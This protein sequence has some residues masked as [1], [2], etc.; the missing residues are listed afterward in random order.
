[1]RPA[2]LAE[3]LVETG[4]D[5]LLAA[6]LRD[7]TGE[8]QPAQQL[9]TSVPGGGCPTWPGG[10]AGRVSAPA[11]PAGCAAARYRRWSGSTLPPK[12]KTSK[13]SSFLLF[14]SIKSN[15][16]HPLINLPCHPFKLPADRWRQTVRQIS[17]ANR[18]NLKPPTDRPLTSW[19]S[20]PGS[21]GSCNPGKILSSRL[22]SDSRFIMPGVAGAGT[23]G[24]QV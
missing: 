18:T 5:L 24:V 12:H 11:P 17:H 21:V 23:A 8:T 22:I 14:C 9:V 7:G 15:K 2:L 6:V 13:Y 3:H 16:I 10:T 1:M 19:T 20:W 4:D